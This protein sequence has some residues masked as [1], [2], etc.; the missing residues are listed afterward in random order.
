MHGIQEGDY[1]ANHLKIMFFINIKLVLKKRNLEFN[2]TKEEF[3]AISQKN[4][5]YCGL[6]PNKVFKAKKVYFGEF[7]YN[8]LD[9]LDNNIGYNLNNIVPCC[10]RCNR[11]KSNLSI[12][13]FLTHI[14]IISSYQAQNDKH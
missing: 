12:E 6:P 11:M 5:F 2:I 10:F 4:C 9:R 8:G 13:E 1:M 7:V 3:T 14:K